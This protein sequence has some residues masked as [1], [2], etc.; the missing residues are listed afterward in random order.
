[1]SIIEAAITTILSQNE[2]IL[3]QN[4]KMIEL[5]KSVSVPSIP[6]IVSLTREVETTPKHSFTRHPTSAEW[7]GSV[8]KNEP[9]REFHYQ[10]ILKLAGNE[11]RNL[12]SIQKCL[13]AGQG[14]GKW[15]RAGHGYWKYAGE[16]ATG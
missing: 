13:S 10:E 2:K 5:L 7:L 4:E 9:T 15:M 14:G 16:T 6:T 11:G 1:M 3:S 8:F 12:R